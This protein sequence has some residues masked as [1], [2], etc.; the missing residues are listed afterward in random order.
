MEKRDYYETL[1]VERGVDAETLKR[2]YRKLAMRYHPDRNPDDAEAETNFKAVSEA[3]GVLSDNEKRAAYDR[4]GHAAFEGA[5]AADGAGFGF[6]G[7]NF[8]DVFDDLFGDFMGGRRSADG[9][10]RGAD[11]RYNLE[12]GLEDA[13]A[14]RRTTVRTTVAVTCESC[15]G[16]G[17]EAGSHPVDCPSCRGL[18]K[19]RAQQGFFTIERTCPRCQGA[20]RIIE[21]PCRTCRGAGRGAREKQLQVDI[22]RGVEDG[23]RIRLAGE[24]EAGLRGGS[25]GDLYIFI[26][27]APHRLFNREGNDLFCRVPLPMVRAALGGTIEVPTLD[28]ERAVVTVPAGTQSGHRFRLRGKGMPSLRGDGSGDLFV[29]TAV[30][31]PVNI[32][33]KQR[34]L[35]QQFEAA[36]NP[37]S[38][39][40]SEGFFA[41]VK[42]LW[43]DLTD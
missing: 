14:G 2:A 10:R 12:I 3:Y 37:G 34:D 15:G 1:G 43:D 20:G 19:V 7:S 23:T 21:S 27:V 39:P 9:R 38:H 17:A 22:P 42:E 29:Q 41:R 5:G 11:V 35:L 16:S 28:G 30:E 8:A 33:A 13:F 31:T 26:G 32:T 6:A 18:G 40:E 4:F 36:G 24:G 25:P